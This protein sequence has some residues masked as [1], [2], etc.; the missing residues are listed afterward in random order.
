MARFRDLP[1]LP[2]GARGMSDWQ[3]YRRLL[4]YIGPHWPIFCLSL[5]GYLFY[6]AGNV[7]LADLMQF[8]LNALDEGS[9]ADAGIVAS[10]AYALAGNSQLSPVEFARIAVPLALVTIASVRAIGFFLGNYCMNYVSRSLIHT[11]RCQV[12]DRMLVAP[13]AY[14][15][16]VNQGAVISRITF[17]VEQVSGAVTKSLKVVVR[18]GITV[19]A[20]VAYLL[21]LNWRL[22]LIF[23]AVT[24][25][26]A[27]VVNQVGKRFRRYSRHIQS[28]MGDVTQV[29]AE[30]VK[31]YREIRVF[32]GQQRQRDRF[33]NASAYN[34]KQNLKLAF[35]EGLSTPVIQT[36]LAV[37]LALLVW[38]ALSPDVLQGFTGPSLAAFLTAATQLSKPIRQLSEVQSD[39]QRGLAASEDI[40]AQLDMEAEADSGQ[41]V[42]EHARGDIKFR[43]VTFSYPDT[44]KLILQ[45]VCF[46]IPAGKTVALVGPSGSGKTTLVQLLTRFYEPI[47]GDILLDDVPIVDY[48]MDN[49][50]AQL[51]IVSQRVALFHDSV[52]NNIAYGSLA[53]ANS[54]AVSAALDA[55]FAREFVESL[56]EGLETHLGDDGS[57]LSGGQQQRIAIARAILKDA[58]V[59]ILDEATSSLDTESEQRI[60]RAMDNVM[61]NRTTLVVAHRLSTVEHADNIIVMDKGKVVASGTH[62][63]LLAEN[64]LYAQ[65]Y[66]RHFND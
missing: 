29:S 37:A 7:L 17:N 26:V 41:R 50:R 44:D 54:E 22:C 64:G 53:K 19:L 27:I 20:L 43:G 4:A 28:S 45:D 60:Q 31:G 36:L 32:G 8:L 63:E 24:P 46:D 58:P 42:I 51:A 13:A 16:S 55:A 2:I 30:S 1:Q 56:P 59:L 47:E 40:F 25:L 52:Y 61:V 62:G 57:G 9:A 34:R 33:R 5:V 35:A 23:V 49:L 39:I 18:E 66:R 3:V 11:L 12:F 65:L 21:H 10:F 6:A 15:D 38:F 14:F 48:R